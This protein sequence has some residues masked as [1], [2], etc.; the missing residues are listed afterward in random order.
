VSKE[1]IP[2][3]PARPPAKRRHLELAPDVHLAVW[4]AGE[5]TPSERRKVQAEKDRRKDRKQPVTVTILVGREG[6]TPVQVREL[7]EALESLNPDAILHTGV[8]RAVHTAC[9]AVAPTTVQP[10]ARENVKCATFVIAL[11]RDATPSPTSPLWS[12]IQYARHRKLPTIVVTPTG[13]RWV[14]GE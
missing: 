9:R 8:P 13:H 1:D 5:L 6:G 3:A 7:R 12:L 10:D 2:P 14:P 11:P 4:L